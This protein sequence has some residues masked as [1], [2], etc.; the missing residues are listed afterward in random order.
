MRER[1]AGDAC[2]DR[3]CAHRRCWIE[4]ADVTELTGL[5]REGPDGDQLAAWPATM[6]V[7]ARRERPHPGA[8]L[9]L[10]ETAGGWRYTLWVTSLPAELRGWRANLACIDAAHRARARVEDRIRTGRDCGI[11]HFPSRSLAINTAWL[12]VSLLAATLLAWLRLLALD[13]DLAKAEPKTL[14]YRVPH[15][16][17]RIIRG[18]RR[19]QLRIPATWPWATDITA[20]WQ[21]ITALP[22][23]P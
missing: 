9:T 10:F 6:R 18:A 17:A 13:G 1:R 19:R 4:E 2:A 15:A 8:Q 21:H 14:R 23:A 3:S 20:A 16:A 7:F 11:G 22:Q 12:T 5:L